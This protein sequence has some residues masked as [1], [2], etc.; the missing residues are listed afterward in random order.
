MERFQDYKE[1]TRRASRVVTIGN[2]DGLHLGH[3]ALIS[4]AKEYATARQLPLWVM[5]FEPH[6][7]AF[8]APAAAPPR[9]YQAA[10]KAELLAAAGVDG[11]LAQRFDREFASLSALTFIEEVLVGALKTASLIVGYDFAF[12]AGRSG[13]RALLQREGERLGFEVDVLEA[14]CWGGEATNADS[15]RS[16][17]EHT[18][19]SSSRIRTTIKEGAVARAA[20]LLSRPYHLSG[21]SL[22]GHQRGRQIGFPTV[23]LA[24]G[25][26][27]CPSPGVYCGW[28]DWGEGAYAAVINLGENP[29]FRE[30]HALAERQ[31]WALEVHVLGAVEV[32]PLYHR[33]CRLWFTKRLRKELTFPSVEALQNQLRVDCSEAQELLSGG[34]APQWPRG[35]LTLPPAC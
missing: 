34:E 24:Y 8:F 6:P 18:V 9:I 2:F 1:L 3:Q 5:S 12:G 21:I 19:V 28:L 25:A 14:R 7:A 35:P 31:R 27:L 13:D 30:P 10:E 23:N 4:R 33:P 11:L 17:T 16:E 29:T 22:P 20:A 26:S 32:P 15:S